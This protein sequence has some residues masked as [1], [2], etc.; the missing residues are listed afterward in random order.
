M[1]DAIWSHYRK[2]ERSLCMCRV[3][4]PITGGG[5]GV[6]MIQFWNPW[7]QF[8]YSLCHFPG[9]A[10][11]IKPCYVRKIAFFPLCRLESSLRMRIIT[12]P[13]H[14]VPPKPRVIIFWPW[15]IYSLYNFYG[16]TMTI[17][18]SL[19]WS[20]PML[21]RFLAAKNE[22]Q[23][24]LAVSQKYKGLYIKY[25][26][27]HPQKALPYLVQRLLTFFVKIRSSP[28]TKKN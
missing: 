2:L 22:V 9:A 19:Y 20:I 7:S 27:R 11:K 15:L 10:T 4:W 21:K 18:V 1:C 16:A 6:N 12:W 13:V 5:R 24:K 14:R 28:K 26:H 8:T 3:T 23:S 17:K 25:S